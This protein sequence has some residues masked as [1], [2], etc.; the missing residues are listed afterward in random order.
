VLCV[1]DPLPD[2]EPII[3]T[4]T[5]LPLYR[6][7]NMPGAG[8]TGSTEAPSAALSVRVIDAVAVPTGLAIAGNDSTAEL[9]PNVVALLPAVTAETAI[10][11]GN[12]RR[13]GLAVTA[14][15]NLYDQGDF[16]QASARLLA[17][18]IEA[19]HLRDREAIVTICR[20]YVLR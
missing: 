2:S 11:L 6:A 20:N 4:N 15:V 17:E 10:A 13:R 5:V 7:L 16:E 3:S 9:M 14:I 12:L 1:T 8:L 18:G 19:R